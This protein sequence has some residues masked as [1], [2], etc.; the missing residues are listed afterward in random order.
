MEYLYLYLTI[1]ASLATA[2]GIYIGGAYYLYLQSVKRSKES[3]DYLSSL[4]GDLKDLREQYDAS[5]SLLGKKDRKPDL[6]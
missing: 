2:V 5:D 4:L 6:H 3:S 1:T